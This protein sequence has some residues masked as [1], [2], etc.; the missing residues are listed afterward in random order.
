V[1]VK[2]LLAL[3]ESGYAVEVVPD[4]GG[5]RRYVPVRTGAFAG[6]LVEVTGDLQAGDPVVVAP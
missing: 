5:A 4:G 3:Q 1:P 2:A 6:G